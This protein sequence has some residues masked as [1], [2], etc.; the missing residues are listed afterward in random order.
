[1]SR[2]LVR[3]SL[4]F[5]T[6]LSIFLSNVPMSFALAKEDNIP[7]QKEYTRS[8]D[9]YTLSVAEFE[10]LLEEDLKLRGQHEELLQEGYE[11]IDAQEY[12][13]SDGITRAATGK[14]VQTNYKQPVKREVIY[15]EDWYNGISALNNPL[16]V[17]VGKII[18]G[19]L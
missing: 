19:C 13:V 8:Y 11:F 18:Y 10:E 16:Q 9:E 4:A 14:I 7:I 12:Y 3:K 17:I 5:V 2:K 15:S 6:S 1:M